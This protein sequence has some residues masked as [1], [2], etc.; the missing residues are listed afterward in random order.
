MVVVC[1]K[2]TDEPEVRL[3]DVYETED[4][5]S[6]PH[7]PPLKLSTPE[8]ANYKDMFLNLVK[9]MKARFPDL[10][11]QVLIEFDNFEKHTSFKKNKKLP[12]TA[13]DFHSD[14]P[15]GC[16][17][18][19]L[20]VQREPM[21]Q[22][23][24][25]F[26]VARE[27]WD[28][29]DEFNKAATVLHE[30]LLRIGVQNGVEHSV[31][32]RYLVGLLLADDLE[33]ISDQD[34]IEAFT[35]S[36]IRNFE[37]GS[38]KIPLFSG[39]FVPCRPSPG[40]VACTR[41]ENLKVASLR[42]TTD[43]RLLAV[44]YDNVAESIRFKSG[45]ISGTMLVKDMFFDYSRNALEI[46]SEGEINLYGPD[47]QMTARFSGRVLPELGV[48]NGAQTM[49]IGKK[50]AMN[51][52]VDFQGSFVQVLDRFGIANTD[53]LPYSLPTNSASTGFLV[54]GSGENEVVDLHSDMVDFHS[55]HMEPVLEP[56]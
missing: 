45:T 28:Q 50:L 31:G 3:L 26:T 36:R 24:P 10:T 1:G 32:V 23:R 49:I 13:D 29:M 22:R 54:I 19:Q 41:I 17:L 9:R 33:N 15:I 4:T 12:D 7:L 56:R 34:W 30:T 35:Q 52:T 6:A 39:A 48:L 2:D 14:L 55:N 27:Y 5:Y 43:R 11:R 37:I 40:T 25:W 51:G 18:K 16:E 47:A 38:L 8:G 46:T 42:Y 21:F 44:S 53:H 20:V